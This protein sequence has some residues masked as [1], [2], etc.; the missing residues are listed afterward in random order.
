MSNNVYFHEIEA[1]ADN[2]RAMETD[3][4]QKNGASPKSHTSRGNFLGKTSFVSLAVGILICGLFFTGC[5]SSDNTPPSGVIEKSLN[6]VIKKDFDTFFKYQYK[7]VKTENVRNNLEQIANGLTK[8]EIINEYILSKEE[9]ESMIIKKG[10]GLA[11]VTV[12]IFYKNGTEDIQEMSLVK[13]SSGWK[14][15]HYGNL[16]N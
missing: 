13:T 10:T 5:G 16:F 6:A 14:V 15:E 4:I 12:K 9:F 1:G 2:S 8:I 11:R 7:P 3:T